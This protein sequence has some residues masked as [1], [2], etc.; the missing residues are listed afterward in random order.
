MSA[1][2]LQGRTILVLEDEP[3]VRLDVS[4]ILR[5]EGA[6]IHSPHTVAEAV[7]VIRNQA[8]SLALLD[9]NLGENDCSEICQLCAARGIPVIFHTG[10]TPEHVAKTWPQA[11]VLS[12]PVTP[13]QIIDIVADVLAAARNSDP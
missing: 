6:R 9:V 5:A 12:K 13:R 8:L 3:L 10:Y 1:G 7:T 2:Q 4:S 11:V